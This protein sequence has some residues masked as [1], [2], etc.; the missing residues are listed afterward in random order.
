MD[1]VIIVPFN[2]QPVTDTDR[3]HYGLGTF[4]GTVLPPGYVRPEFR[5]PGVPTST[6]FLRCDWWDGSAGR[7]RLR[8]VGIGRRQARDGEGR[9]L[10]TIVPDLS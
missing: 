8:T 2:V 10:V 5:K 1:L 6:G 3:V 7:C 9:G 4:A